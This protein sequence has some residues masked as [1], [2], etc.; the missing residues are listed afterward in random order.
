MIDL[1]GDIHQE[2]T[3]RAS[4]PVWCKYL[5]VAAPLIVTL[6]LA[7]TLVFADGSN[8]TDG[9]SCNL[10]VQVFGDASQGNS[11]GE[12]PIQSIDQAL[13]VLKYA[14]KIDFAKLAEHESGLLERAL[15]EAETERVAYLKARDDARASALP[16]PS[17]P[18]SFN[19]ALLKVLG[20]YYENCVKKPDPEAD[21]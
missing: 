19:S 12:E 2:E 3:R 4:I 5:L 11:E 20:L 15:L 21:N 6:S 17:P 1:P 13:D 14:H 16:M 7:M 10:F 9:S 8:Q 18:A